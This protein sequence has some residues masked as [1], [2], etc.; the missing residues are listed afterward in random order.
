MS[1]NLRW[2]GEGAW[3]HHRD[4]FVLAGEFIS[5]NKGFTAPHTDSWLAAAR[6]SLQGPRGRR[7]PA[8][9]GT[10]MAVSPCDG[11]E[12][13]R[14]CHGLLQVYLHD[15]HP[16]M[17]GLRAG[18]I[19]PLDP[20]G[21][22]MFIFSLFLDEQQPL[23]PRTERPDEGLSAAHSLAQH[24]RMKELLWQQLWRDLQP[25]GEGGAAGGQATG[26]QGLEA[27]PPQP[28]CPNIWQ[29]LVRNPAAPVCRAVQ[30]FD[31]QAISDL[32]LHVGAPPGWEARSRNA[33]NLRL[34]EGACGCLLM[35][36]APKGSVLCCDLDRIL[37][38][39]RGGALTPS[40]TQ[41]LHWSINRD[42]HAKGT[43]HPSA[44]SIQRLF[45]FARFHGALTLEEFRLALWRGQPP[46]AK[47]GHACMQ[48]ELKVV[49]VVCIV[50][51]AVCGVRCVRCVCCMCSWCSCDH[52]PPFP[53]DWC[54]PFH[55]NNVD[56][57]GHATATHQLGGQLIRGGGHATA[58]HQLIRGGGHAT[59][60]HR[61]GVHPTPPACSYLPS[62]L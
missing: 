56:S 27:P 9:V 49:V 18:D 14:I 19:P 6:D 35:L 42:V 25:E 58:T 48:W 60:T 44:L 2:W 21:A 50:L 55:R 15:S 7:T 45:Q 31:E 59:A 34:L 29:D 51:C 1:H 4:A 10:M 43:M 16:F 52:P 62:Y 32:F 28:L 39:A 24:R 5:S 3:V 47:D 61:L 57:G 30:P 33:N 37:P 41:L 22:F 17:A 54:Q 53:S 38:A 11:Q 13:D 8:A 12:L 26:E 46:G 20:Y 40:N 36:G 23:L